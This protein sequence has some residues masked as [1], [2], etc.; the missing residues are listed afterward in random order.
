MESQCFRE[1]HENFSK[2]SKISVVLATLLVQV[3]RGVPQW[4]FFLV[5]YRNSGKGPLQQTSYALQE[6]QL[7][8]ILQSVS[9]FCCRLY[10]L[11]AMTCSVIGGTA[12]FYLLSKLL[13][14]IADQALGCSLLLPLYQ[15]LFLLFRAQHHSLNN[16]SFHI[17][18]QRGELYFYLC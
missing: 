18:I 1:I 4:I 12:V 5:L 9:Q 14:N 7:H 16:V 15:F 10:A 13:L 3:K 2:S 8:V 6:T 11:C 17:G